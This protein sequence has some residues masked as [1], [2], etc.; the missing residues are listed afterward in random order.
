MACTTCIL[1][2]QPQT[3][4]RV[5][6]PH[7]MDIVLGVNGRGTSTTLAPRCLVTSEFVRILDITTGLHLLAL[8][9]AAHSHPGV[10][11]QIF[12]C[13]AITP[14]PVEH[15]FDLIFTSSVAW[16]Q[17]ELTDHIE[18]RIVQ[19]FELLK[20]ENI[21]TQQHL[22]RKAQQ[23]PH[24]DYACHHSLRG[25][26]TSTSRSRTSTSACSSCM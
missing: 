26:S 24:H 21:T 5:P 11:G 19:R 10:H 16:P 9:A 1:H 4:S 25:R 17:L 15:R 20:S 18:E 6:V 22:N 23:H 3:S 7:P 14:V 8:P 13:R 12:R 2:L